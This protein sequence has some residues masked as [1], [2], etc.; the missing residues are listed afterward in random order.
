MSSSRSSHL[1]SERWGRAALSVA[2]AVLAAC[3]G[4]AAHGGAGADAGVLDAASEPAAPEVPRVAIDRAGLTDLGSGALDYAD[5]A[6]WACRPG[7]DPNACHANLDATEVH[8]DGSLEVVPHARAERPAFDCFYLYPAVAVSGGGNLR[9]FSDLTPVLDPLLAQAARFNRV[10]ELYAPLYRQQSLRVDAPGEPGLDGDPELALQDVLAAF[11]Q[12]AEGLGRGRKFV[13]LGHS[14]GATLGLELLARRVEHDP[15]LR[16]RFISAVL[17][18]ASPT[19][20][21]GKPAGGT[22]QDIALC[23]APGQ[24]G[25]LIAYDSFDI[26]APP[27]PLRARLGSTREPGREVACSEPG[28]LANNHGNYRGSYFAAHAQSASFELPGY[29]PDELSTPFVLYRDYFSAR[30]VHNPGSSYL[31]LSSAAAAGDLRQAP[32]YRSPELEQAGWGLHLADFQPA[33]DDLIEA[34][35]LQAAVA[36]TP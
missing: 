3:S 12:Y 15:A 22:F 8:K 2:A 7:N 29:R 5:P 28:S 18:G 25:C 20:Q 1:G 36:L 23:S 19:V 16:A 6:L 21:L 32:P 4:S 13:I 14:Q 17:L 31:E 24:V 26:Q 27:D 30:C 34:V 9:D 11:E 35:S 33:L 10:C